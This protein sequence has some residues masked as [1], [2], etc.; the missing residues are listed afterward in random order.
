MTQF[1]KTAVLLGALATL[2]ACNDE[3]TAPPPVDNEPLQLALQPVVDGLTNAILVTAPQNDARLFIVER[4]GRVRIIKNG[5]LLATP[6]LDITSRVGTVYSRGLLGMAFHPEYANN[7]KFYVY[8]IDRQDNVVVERF[9]SNPATDVASPSDGVVISFHHGGEDLHGGTL[10]FGPDGMLY[11]ASGDGGCCDDVPNNSQNMGVLLGKMVRI[12]VRNHPYTVPASNPFVGRPGVRP[13]I[14]ASGLRNPWRFTFDAPS[15]MLY[16]ADVGERERE[17]LNVV[18]STTAGLNYGWR[19]MEGSACFNPSVDCANGLT[20]TLPIHE[21]GHAYPPEPYTEYAG[22]AI[23]GGYVYRGSAIPE[24]NGHYFYSDY[25]AGWL[26]S[27]RVPAPGTVADH[28]FWEGIS[29]PGIAS[30]GRDGMGE[31]YVVEET[32]V[33]KIVRR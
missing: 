2:A 19:L 17:E 13:E 29:V 8:Y 16:I 28:R 12:D 5:E 6:F 18:P 4:I 30:F 33:S 27:L 1:R 3:P 10:E 26:H 23:V 22:C 31:L 15:Q 9:S 11:F 25:C 7:G 32:R 14:W 20:L 24:L 21:Y